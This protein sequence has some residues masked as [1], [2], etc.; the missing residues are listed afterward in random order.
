MIRALLFDLDGTLLD[1]SLETFLP[2]YFEALVAK[3][4]HLVPPQRFIDQIMRSTRVVMANTDPTRTNAQVFAEDFFPAIGLPRETLMPIFE[5]FYAHE[6]GQLRVYTRPRPGARSVVESAFAAGYQVAIATQPVFP[7]T[8]LQQRLEWAGVGDFDY[9]LITSYERMHTCK[10]RP[11][12]YEEVCAL[13]GRQPAECLMIGDSLDQDIEPAARAGLRTFWVTEG[14]DP[15]APADWQGGLAD[16][17][18]LIESG[19]LREG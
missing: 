15:A 10:P 17:Q 6:Y 14:L 13:L 9:A 11:A 12:Y 7:A 16:L 8:A 5:D 4:A 3:V 19:A 18:R 2:P 1:S